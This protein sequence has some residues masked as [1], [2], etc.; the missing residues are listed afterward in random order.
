MSR[1]NPNY[2]INQGLNNLEQEVE[3]EIARGVNILNGLGANLGMG[4]INTNQN[5]N[6]NLNQNP[7]HNHNQN[8]NPNHISN[9]MA[10]SKISNANQ[11]RA[12][13][14]PN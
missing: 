14:D 9:Y 13:Q 6:H 3:E 10:G 11:S 12:N 7:N 4:N 8:H 2:D 1:V 5:L